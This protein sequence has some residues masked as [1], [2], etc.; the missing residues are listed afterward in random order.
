MADLVPLD[1]NT[2]TGEFIWDSHGGPL[3]L[4]GNISS[5]WALAWLVIVY[6]Y[7]RLSSDD[8]VK[9][10]QELGSVKNTYMRE[11]RSV[12]EMR[13]SEREL[14]HKRLGNLVI[15]YMDESKR[16]DVLKF[17]RRV[18]SHIMPSLSL[19]NRIFMSGPA[20][21][22]FVSFNNVRR[23]AY[24]IYVITIAIS[25]MVTL[26]LVILTLLYVLLNR[27]ITENIS[28]LSEVIQ[29]IVYFPT[30]LL[31]FLFLY[32]WK[33]KY[34]HS[35]KE[36]MDHFVDICEDIE[37]VEK[38][39]KKLTPFLLTGSGVINGFS[40]YD[41]PVLFPYLM[42]KKINIS[43][44]FDALSISV[45]RYDYVYFLI[46]ISASISFSVSIFYGVNESYGQFPVLLI[47]LLSILAFPLFVIILYGI[48]TLCA[49]FLFKP[50]I[51]F[52]IR[53]TYQVD[54][55]R[56]ATKKAG[57]LL[58][59]DKTGRWGTLSTFSIVL[60]LIFLLFSLFLFVFLRFRNHSIV[61]SIVVSSPFFVI[62]LLLYC[63]TMIVRY[64]RMKNGRTSKARY[65][66]SG[67]IIKGINTFEKSLGVRIFKPEQM[68][69]KG[70]LAQYVWDLILI[71]VVF[72]SVIAIVFTTVFPV[73]MEAPDSEI[74]ILAS[75]FIQFP[76]LSA[77]II[78]FI[79]FGFFG[80]YLVYDYLYRD[81][82]DPSL[83]TILEKKRSSMINSLSDPTISEKINDERFAFRSLILDAGMKFVGKRKRN[84]QWRSIIAFVGSLLS[85]I[86]STLL[87]IF[88]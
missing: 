11:G 35:L 44:N 25:F 36:Q 16:K 26:Y 41:G 20:N 14:L 8:I 68:I 71:Y 27:P 86:I 10:I 56:L 70:F 76:S 21:F 74:S 43:W 78:S 22:R 39:M 2:D 88:F 15:D 60:S 58:E 19:T 80:Y 73:L 63:V 30:F 46:F 75:P 38:T 55:I 72:I 50:L 45:S 6:K 13:D 47:V 65:D 34:Q 12:N 48:T 83:S 17:N 79:L 29:Y 66:K 31:F 59:R 82:I 84:K 85:F 53:K 67:K 69:T 61:F 87:S 57:G 28:S 40:N 24:S 81:R 23:L 5:V 9:L 1:Y 3:V 52:G 4:F 77:F 54:S 42:F 64:I 33:R 49:L 62:F 32:R 7:K 37:D 18:S 51:L